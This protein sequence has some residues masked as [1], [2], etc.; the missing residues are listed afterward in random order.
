MLLMQRKIPKRTKGWPVHV[1]GEEYIRGNWRAPA[2]SDFYHGA[3]PRIDVNV[4][5]GTTGEITCPKCRQFAKP[6][7]DVSIPIG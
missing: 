7:P 5:N 6:D 1:A 4:W 3:M 2:C